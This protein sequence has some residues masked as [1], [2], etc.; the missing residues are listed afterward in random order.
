MVNLSS[1]TLQTR[2]NDHMKVVNPKKHIGTINQIAQYI[3]DNAEEAM[4]LDS[5]A[6]QFSVSKYHLNRLFFAQTG[7]NPGE[8]MQRRQMELAYK[9]IR[10]KDMSVIDAAFRVGYGSP[11]SFSRA[12]RKLFGI[13][14]NKVKLK[15]THQFA[16]AALIK[17]PNREV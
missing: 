8:F 14:P 17:K 12:F 7:M 11:A 2:I 5:L 13:E 6:R 10:S 3:Y 9:L 1:V 15:Q 4:S 16:L